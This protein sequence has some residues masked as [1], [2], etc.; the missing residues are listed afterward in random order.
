[1][2]D[3]RRP[4]PPGEGCTVK[5]T[6]NTVKVQKEKKK[7]ELSIEQK[8][9]K[10]ERDRAY[11]QKRR[12]ERVRLCRHCGKEFHPSIDRHLFC[13]DECAIAHREESRK[14]WDK[15]KYQKKKAAKENE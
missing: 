15:A 13:S 4:C 7:R 3:K 11:Q 14:K 1:M 9:R 8:R 12:A 6:N 2:E 10:A 5:V